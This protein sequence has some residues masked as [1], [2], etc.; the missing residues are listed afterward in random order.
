VSKKKKDTAK[1]KADLVVAAAREHKAFDLVLLDVANLSS[2]TDFFFI[3]SC[4][5]NR[6]VQAVADH[7]VET[8]KKRGGYNP[9]G[10]EGKAQGH[11]VL[12]DFGEVIAH[13]F[14]EPVRE[15]FD[16]EG[17][18]IEAPRPDLDAVPAAPKA[19]RRRT[20]PKEI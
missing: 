15:V 20:V 8:V 5:S 11:W 18:W 6:Q 10:V 3:C 9:L 17:L 1:E 7:I 2:I 14:Y 19:P 13:V 12:V 4:K 16:L